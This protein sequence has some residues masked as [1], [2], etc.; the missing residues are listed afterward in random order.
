MSV[1]EMSETNEGGLIR[2]PFIGLVMPQAEL[3]RL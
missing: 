3:L 1:T 2:V